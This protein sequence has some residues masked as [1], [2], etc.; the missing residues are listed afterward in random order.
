[1][2]VGAVQDNMSDCKQCAKSGT[3]ETVCWKRLKDVAKK[4]RGQS[5][6]PVPFNFKQ[7]RY[8]ARHTL[9]ALPTLKSSTPAA[10]WLAADH[11][12]RKGCLSGCL[13]SVG[14]VKRTFQGD[15]RGQCAPMVCSCQWLFELLAC[16]W[17]LYV[18]RL[19]LKLCDPSLPNSQSCI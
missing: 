9:V 7:A 1:V 10:S 2:R 16:P 15:G 3:P 5:T 18:P 11:H 17:L 4:H 13:C 8:T 19:P 12:H 6:V 14:R